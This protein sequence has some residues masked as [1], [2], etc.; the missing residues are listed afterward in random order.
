MTDVKQQEV[1]DEVKDTSES[2][3]LK[4]LRTNFDKQKAENAKLKS[5]LEAVEAEKIKQQD[6]ALKAQGK[7]E[8]LYKEQL[9]RNEDLL[10]NQEKTQKDNLLKEALLQAGVQHKYMKAALLEL[11]DALDISKGLP[12]EVITRLKSDY[13]VYFQSSLQ[14]QGTTTLTPTSTPNGQ[15][16]DISSWSPAEIARNIDKI[17]EA[18]TK[19]LLK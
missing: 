12:D 4:N 13:E 5:Q 15:A 11:P 16:L 3:G 17:N 8:E 2:E 10:K 7:Y 14:P 18:K 6:E 1:K 19:G 9:Q